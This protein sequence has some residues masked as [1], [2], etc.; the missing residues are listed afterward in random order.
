M[1]CG[2]SFGSAGADIRPSHSALPMAVAA[3]V[4]MMVNMPSLVGATFSLFLKPV[5]AE[6]HWGRDS[7]PLAV[8]IAFTLTTVLYPFVGRVVDRLGARTVLLPGMLLLGCSVLSLS[9]L[10]GSVLGFNAT[11]LLVASTGTLVSGVV[12]GRALASAYDENR[13]KAFGLCLGLGGGLGATLSPPL[14]NWLINDFGWR[15]A[16][17]GLG[18]MPIL[19][20]FPIVY[21]FIR[22]I[23]GRSTKVPAGAQT[24][25]AS[26]GLSV[27]EAVRSP[28][29]WLICTVIFLGCLANNGVLVHLA[30]L[31]T[32][33]GLSVGL[34]TG[35]LSTVAVATSLGQCASGFLLDRISTPR[36]GIPFAASV[37]A[38]LLLIDHG[39]THFLLLLG[40]G[41]FGFG[42]GAEYSLLP[43]YIGR[44]FGVRAFG[45]LYG[46]IYAAASIAG[47]VGPFVMGRTFELTRS[48]GMALKGFEAGIVI[49][50]LC[51]ASLGRYVY[52]AAPEGR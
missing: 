46:G 4:G 20:G 50:I 18:L 9:L 35:L 7:M 19:V 51:V 1:T 44:Y 34:A 24:G 5:S 27:A 37:L 42:V 8:M 2:L 23:E 41:L 52:T 6:F 15:S 47:G 29:L 30:A 26:P 45:Q 43:Y 31:L 14:A 36:I 25:A 39:T 11:F 33:R 22:P 49:A 16:Y 38:G 3:T 13:G 12:F 32:D 28:T 10:R 21:L 48:Y 40:V 17:V